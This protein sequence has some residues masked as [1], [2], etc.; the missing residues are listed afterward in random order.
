MILSI[1]YRLSPD[2]CRFIMID[3]KMLEL[4]VYDGIPHLLA[5]VVTD[6]KK[7]IVALK[8]TVR[9]MEDRYR[10]MAKIGVRG[11]AAYNERAKE[12]IDKGEHFERTV[13][14]GFDDAGRPIFESEKIRP[15]HMPYLVV[16]IDEVADL[17]MEVGN[18]TSDER[19]RI[20]AQM[21]AAATGRTLDGT[22]TEASALLSGLSRGAGVVVTTKAN[23]RLK[24][25]EFVR[26]DPT[27]ALVV[28]VA[29]DGTV[30][31]R[32]LSL[33]PGLPASALTEAA[34]F[35]NARILGKTLGE[36]GA[37]V[38]KIEPPAG[39]PARAPDCRRGH[40]SQRSARPERHPEQQEVT[41]GRR[42]MGFL[43]G[44]LAQHVAAE[45]VGKEGLARLHPPQPGGGTIDDRQG[46][47]G[48]A[49]EHQDQRPLDQDAGRQRRPE[50]GGLRPGFARWL[51]AALPG[52]SMASVFASRASTPSRTELHMI[53]PASTAPRWVT[54]AS[55]VQPA[56]SKKFYCFSPIHIRQANIHDHEIYRIPTC[57][58]HTLVSRRSLSSS[59][60]RIVRAV[61]PA[62]SAAAL[63][64]DDPPGDRD[65]SHGFT[66][67]PYI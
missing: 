52:S 34:N 66:V 17:M 42:A 65:G 9:E 58:R 22:L 14:T 2:Q 64:P 39:D 46:Q 6:S 33:P 4:S 40:S 30:E 50:Y 43:R 45:R 67:R 27:R 57:G 37:D 28:L 31:N 24:H 5:P 13:Q 1:L 60:K 51:V 18:L 61:M 12:A 8:W 55:A 23:A 15:E 54:K 36:F 25:I 48:Q 10:R 49:D 11:I 20:E 59:T 38:I 63:P 35:L 26:L 7:A 56:L 19:T 44:D 21:K 41:A 3:P 53:S 29:D 16:V 62:A 47:N 32:L